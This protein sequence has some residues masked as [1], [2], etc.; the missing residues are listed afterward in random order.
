MNFYSIDYEASF[1]DIRGK[2]D[3]ENINFKTTIIR[4]INEKTRKKSKFRIL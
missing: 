4:E 2:V 3:P 1:E